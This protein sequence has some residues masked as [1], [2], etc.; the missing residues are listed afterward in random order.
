MAWMNHHDL[1]LPRLICGSHPIRVPACH[2]LQLARC[3]AILVADFT[4]LRMR[5][6][7]QF[8]LYFIGL[9]NPRHFFPRFLKCASCSKVNSIFFH[10]CS[11]RDWVC[12]LLKKITK[13]AWDSHVLPHW[14]H[15]L[16]FSFLITLWDLI[17]FLCLFPSLCVSCSL[18]H[19]SSPLERV[20]GC[21]ADIKT[22]PPGII[23]Q[24]HPV[25]WF[26]PVP[27][28]GFLGRLQLLQPTKSDLFSGAIVGYAKDVSKV[29]PASSR[30]F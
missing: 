8:C 11:T 23:C 3:R 10:W 16:L 2:S 15:S 5:H 30:D 9:V 28:S 6:V 17:V 1:V 24:F 7:L 25:S 22:V 21:Y 4:I 29:F 27:F 19:N 13:P 12:S 26:A 14:R 20:W 18:V